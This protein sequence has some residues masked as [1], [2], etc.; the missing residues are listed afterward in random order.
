MW[1][2]REKV[3][4]RGAWANEAGELILHT[5]NQVMIGGRWV[6]PGVHGGF[7][8]PTAPPI[9][10]PGLS[11]DDGAG[12]QLLSWLKTWNWARPS[13]DPWLL[14]GWIGC[15][16]YGAAPKWRPIVWITG[17][18]A[19]GKSTLQDLVNGVFDGG[20]L[21][22][23]DATEAAVR[24][25][26][27]QQ[28]LPVAIDE[29]E[30]EEDNRKLMALV[31]LARQ[32]ASGGRILRG[33]QDHQ[34]HE[35]IARSCFLFSSILVP[36]IPPQ[37][38]SRLAVL[39][40][41][42]LP[43]SARAPKL[44]A[45]EMRAIGATLRR[46]LADRW[47]QFGQVLGDYHNA[48]IDFGGHGGRTADQFG[49]LLA[50]AHVMLHDD[51][52][53]DVELTTWG[54][55][56]AYDTLAERAD[57]QSEAERC[58]YHLGSSVVQLAGHGQPRL[59]AD[60][61]GEA[62]KPPGDMDAD[63]A[64]ARAML[65]KIGLGVHIGATTKGALDDDKPRP[66]PGRQ[67]I[68]VANAHQGL[69]RQF[70][71]SHW[72]GR[73]GASGVWSQALKRIAGAVPGSRQRVGG[74]VIA[75]TLVPIEALIAPDW[76]AG[77]RSGTRGGAV[78]VPASRSM[79]AGP[80]RQPVVRST[81]GD[82]AAPS[83]APFKARDDN[84]LQSQ[85]PAPALSC[86]NLKPL[87]SI[88]F[89]RGDGCLTTA[90]MLLLLPGFRCGVT[91]GVTGLSFHPNGLGGCYSSYPVLQTPIRAGAHTRARAHMYTH[92]YPSNMG[93]IWIYLYRSWVYLLLPL[94]LRPIFR[95]TWVTSPADGHL[96]GRS[97]PCPIKIGGGYASAARG[98][99]PGAD[100]RLVAGVAG[101]KFRDRNAGRQLL[102]VEGGNGGFLRV[103]AG[104]LGSVGMAMLER[105]SQAAGNARH[106]AIRIQPVRLHARPIAGRA[107]ASPLAARLLP[108]MSA[109]PVSG[110]WPDIVSGRRHSDG[111]R[112][113][114]SSTRIGSGYG[115]SG[116]REGPGGLTAHGG[117]RERLL[118][119][120]GI[121]VLA[122]RKSLV[123][124]T[125]WAG[126]AGVN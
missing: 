28:S 123:T 82:R 96:I 54:R 114:T 85:P 93:N 30:A 66:V 105:A 119:D 61:V 89:R 44:D 39:E 104:R 53:D 76:R 94:L 90:R 111:E 52:P 86:P 75:C 46:R 1:N 34:G 97:L 80:R 91:C 9:P 118:R 122:G 69:T 12:K 81:V 74:M 16:M 14:L 109:L 21:Q 64:K 31:K 6:K 41:G 43:A 47:D 101:G 68:V 2:A 29:A 115:L 51:A 126:V 103:S 95:V 88:R 37:D 67:Y 107:G 5:G 60:W 113:Q 125:L 38:R 99:S 112:A 83:F 56:L 3:R 121:P 7:V 45:G 102:A 33:G 78:T 24:Q 117:C 58:L 62:G 18:K 27:G 49:T 22:T 79:R 40:L 4:G 110:R 42:E 35:F 87:I 55:R 73:S 84:R 48:M 124:G 10:R 71:G 17:D 116:G 50:A 25:I 98:T 36:P 65:A 26:L 19:T 100:L 57:E 77:R 13:I 120:R 106:S 92:S 70:E 32:A 15:A 20:L 72:A 63:P 108:S 23:S 11:G 59:V 8:Y